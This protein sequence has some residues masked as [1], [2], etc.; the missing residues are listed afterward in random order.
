MVIFAFGGFMEKIKLDVLEQ[1][2]ELINLREKMGLNR[3]IFA[4][5]FGIPLRTVEDWEA[6]RRKMPEYLLR[7]MFYR[8][9]IDGLQENGDKE[10]INMKTPKKIQII[11]KNMEVKL[12]MDG[13]DMIPD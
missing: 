3:K 4:E 2:K 8:V 6:G 1:K 10:K 13:I 9:K 5:Y 12:N 11:K 7:L